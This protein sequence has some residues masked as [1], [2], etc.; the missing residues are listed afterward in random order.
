MSFGL[1][2]IHTNRTKPG[3][4]GGSFATQKLSSNEELTVAPNTTGITA[5]TNLLSKG[6]TKTNWNSNSPNLFAN[7]K[8][9]TTQGNPNTET[10]NTLFG[11]KTQS[12]SDIKLDKNNSVFSNK[13]EQ[14]LSTNPFASNCKPI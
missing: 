3:L 6:L 12:L 7:S 10:L 1:E 11:K 2:I 9:I 8:D 5:R 4:F 14:R 13:Y